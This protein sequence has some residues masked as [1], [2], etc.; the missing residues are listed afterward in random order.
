MTNSDIKVW[1]FKANVIWKKSWQALLV[2]F[3]FEHSRENLDK[4]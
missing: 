1:I 2:L 3:S 4:K